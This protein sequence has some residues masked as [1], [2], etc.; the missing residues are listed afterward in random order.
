MN[1]Q[2]LNKIKARLARVKN[3][4][5]Q[6]LLYLYCA[7]KRNLDIK[8]ISAPDLIIFPGNYFT[9]YWEASGCYKIII[10]DSIVL[11]G[12]TTRAHFDSARL[13][14]NLKICFYGFRQVIEKSMALNL[15]NAGLKKNLAL[16]ET[17]DRF[18]AALINTSLKSFTVHKLKYK[19][20]ALPIVPKLSIT[21]LPFLTRPAPFSTFKPIPLPV[22]HLDQFNPEH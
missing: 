19:A 15:I 1:R 22:I 21:P 2:S 12:N 7:F 8:F 13:P 10:N 16:Q 3:R 20:T 14:G 9:L 18:K 4:L 17:P 11:P 6:K 5:T